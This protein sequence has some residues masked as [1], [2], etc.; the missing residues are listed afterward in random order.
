MDASLCYL[1]RTTLAKSEKDKL[2]APHSNFE[3]IKDISKLEKHFVQVLERISKK[4][5][6]DDSKR[7]FFIRL[8]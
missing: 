6:I 7:I 2:R 1:L 4:F 5:A 8:R 3:E